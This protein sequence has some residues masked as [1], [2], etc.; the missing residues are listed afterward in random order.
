MPDRLRAVIFVAALAPALWLSWLAASGGLGANPIK[1]I[2]HFT[3]DWTLN[4]LLLTLAITP[5]RRLTGWLQVVRY[6]RML[7]LFT[8]FYA[9]LHF[10]T[11]LVLDQ[12]FAWQEIL[13]DI[14]KRPYITV[15]FTAFV[16]LVPLAVT[17]TR[18]M[19][20]RLGPNWRRLHRAVYVIG[21]LGVLHYLWGVKA[22]ILV[23]LIYGGVLV[24]LLMLRLPV[25]AFMRQLPSGPA[26]SDK[27]HS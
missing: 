8:F 9:S 12:F 1:E 23:P 7:G 18:R 26:R 16:L 14:A 4:L 22:D 21:T 3:G 11:W 17:S 5:L 6:R 27:A 24:T 13:K 2:T 10:L 20:M 19:A 25:P 15:G